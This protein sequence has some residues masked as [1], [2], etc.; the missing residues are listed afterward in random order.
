[1]AAHATSRISPSSS[2]PIPKSSIAAAPHETMSKRPEATGFP[3]PMGCS[4]SLRQP[5]S[6]PSYPSICMVPTAAAVAHGTKSLR[7]ALR[8]AVAP[9]RS[10]GPHI[11]ESSPT[12]QP[13]ICKF[14][15][16]IV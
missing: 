5:T 1:M 14:F 7:S 8:H 16:I 15:C 3:T 10:G 13:C 11:R 12:A 9:V 4:P 6:A 2:P